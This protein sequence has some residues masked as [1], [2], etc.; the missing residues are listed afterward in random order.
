M[1]KVLPGVEDVLASFLLRE[2]IL[3]KLDLPTLDLPI[4]AYSGL[5]SLGH[6][7]SRGDD[8]V[9]SAVLISIFFEII[10]GRRAFY[11]RHPFDVFFDLPDSIERPH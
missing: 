8:S 4:N 11:A 9:N 2:S 10:K 5:V 1:S 6:I 7:D 3:I